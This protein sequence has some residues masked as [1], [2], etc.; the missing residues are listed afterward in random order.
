MTTRTRSTLRTQPTRRA[1]SNM[2]HPTF[3]KYRLHPREERKWDTYRPGG[4]TPL[5]FWILQQT[6]ETD[7]L[8]T[9][10]T[11]DKQ[12]ALVSILN[13]NDGNVDTLVVLSCHNYDMCSHEFC[14]H[15]VGCLVSL[16]LIEYVQDVLHAHYLYIT[17]DPI[18]KGHSV[19]NII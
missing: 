19:Y 5:S 9:S 7:K 10:L 17:M 16:L 8:I 15:P 13:C 1:M 18:R 4:T 12:N 14:T 2:P 6:R 11:G 3:T